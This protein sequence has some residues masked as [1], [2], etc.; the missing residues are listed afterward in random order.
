MPRSLRGMMKK[1]TPVLV[2]DQIE[3]VLPLWDALQFSR[4]VEMPHENRIGFV[5]LQNGPVE[6]MYQS[7]D[8]IRGDCPRALERPFG[9][10]AVFIEVENLDAVAA[11]VPA[12]TTVIEKRRKT[13]YGSTEMI[14]R[15]AAGHMITFAQMG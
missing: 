3:P 8:S 5:I 2:V 10:A 1:L 14:V 12:A 11:R 15:D 6:V 4:T 13:A 9:L 7:I